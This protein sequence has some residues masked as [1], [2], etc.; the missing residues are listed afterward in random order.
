[1]VICFFGRLGYG[2]SAN[3]ELPP[4]LDFIHH[5]ALTELPKILSQ[6]K[7]GKCILVGNSDVASFALI[8]SAEN[9]S[10][11]LFGIVNEAPQVF[12]EKLTR[13]FIEKVQELYLTGNLREL[14]QKNH[15]ANID[16]AFHGWAYVCLHPDFSA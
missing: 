6:Y 5:E 14:L 1:M 12:C 4:A 16:C 2:K 11:C 13:E 10:E 8:H 15:G 9:P 3:C 7:I